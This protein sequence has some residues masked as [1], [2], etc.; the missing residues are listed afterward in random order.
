MSD[1]KWLTVVDFIQWIM[2]GVRDWKIGNGSASN[3]Q[4]MF[5]TFVTNIK[6]DRFSVFQFKMEL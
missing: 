2:H 3:G 6:M 1:V 5:S 4:S